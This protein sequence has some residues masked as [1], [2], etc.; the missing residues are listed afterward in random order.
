MNLRGSIR[1]S[2]DA[3]GRRPGV[4]GPWLHALLAAGLLTGGVSSLEAGGG[5][6][7]GFCLLHVE[8][9]ETFSAPGDVEDP[10][11]SIDWCESGGAVVPSGFCPTGGAYRLDPGDRI[12]ARIA[13]VEVCGR[14]RITFLASSL[15]DTWSRI[16]I[17]PAT[18]DCAGPAVRTES[19]DVSKGACLPFEVDY[20]IPEAHV[21]EDLLVRWVHGDGTGVLLVDQITFEALACCDPPAHGCC[22]VGGGGCDDQAIEA[23]VCAIDP[24]CCETAWDTLCID[25]IAAGGC[26]ACESDCLTTFE[27]DFGEDYVPGGPCQVFP[28]LFETCTGLGPFLTTSGG[29]AAS[30]DAALRFGGGFPWSTLETRCLDLSAAGTAVLRFSC[31]TSLGVAGPVV[32][33]VGVDGE[34]VEILRVPFASEPGCREFAVDLTPHFTGS[35]A[36]LRFRS[37]SSV[38]D[39]TRIDDIRIELDPEHAACDTGPPG[40]AD[41][42]IEACVCGFDDYCCKTEWDSICVTL[43]TLACGAGCESIPTCGSG[44]ACGIVHDE[45]GCEDETCC[46]AVCLEDPFCCVSSWDDFCVAGAIIACTGDRPGDLDDDG[47]VDGADLGLLLA[48]WGG[49]DPDADL[50]GSGTVDGGDLGLMLANWG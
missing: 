46:T 45:P 6:E 2:D 24:Y 40:C 26:G 8:P 18:A 1:G 39:A 19:I 36:R 17:G 32:E 21:G 12:A 13:A 4:P 30:G 23:C 37:G 20:E 14:I 35:G 33:I 5:D 9:F 25:A 49:A 7:P 48:V 42:E 28:G 38:A 16:E 27:A 50:D 34:P 22:E 11:F 29:C 47:V 41:P 10:R 15:F 44:G 43:A 31:S 3:V